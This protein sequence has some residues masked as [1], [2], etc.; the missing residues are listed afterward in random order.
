MSWVR[1]AATL[2]HSCHKFVRVDGSKK[3]EFYV[4]HKK[5]GTLSVRSKRCDHP[6][7]R[8]RSPY[9]MDG[10]KTARFCVEYNKEGMVDVLS[11]KCGHSGCNKWPSYGMDGSKTKEFCAGH[12]KKGMVSVA[13]KRSCHPMLQQ[14]V[15]VLRHG[16]QQDGGVLR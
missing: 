4:E 3:A 10:S 7:C 6:S 16:Q 8:K 12:A 2:L 11:Q 14:A 5:E 9:G 15:A 13:D 1:G